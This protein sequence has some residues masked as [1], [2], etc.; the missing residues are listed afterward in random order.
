MDGRPEI[1]REDRAEPSRGVW[2]AFPDWNPSHFLDTAEMAHAVGIGYDWIHDYLDE[3]TRERIRSAIVELGLK[4]GI[5]RHQSQ[6]KH[7]TYAYNWNQVCNGG[8][9]IGALA[10]ADTGPEVAEF[11]VT[12]ALEHL[13]TALGSYAPDGVWAE[14]IGYWNYATE[15]TAFALTALN[16]A[17]GSDFDLSKAPSLSTTGYVPLYSITR[18]KMP[19]PLPS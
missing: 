11:I 3:E 6:Y 2:C 15:Y 8:L 16:T 1:C 5:E 13:P 14:G 4:P 18:T 17:L 12:K 19:T 10:V 9:L 7:F